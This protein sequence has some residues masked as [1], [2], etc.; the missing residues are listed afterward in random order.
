M[1]LH[2][3]TS[4][5]YFLRCNTLTAVS[6]TAPSYTPAGSNFACTAMRLVTVMVTVF[7]SL[8][9]IKDG[10]LQYLT[11]KRLKDKGSP[12]YCKLPILLLC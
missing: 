9:N 2:C 10:K 3:W 4:L 8:E 11:G 1:W 12:Q 6:I 7:D 5:K